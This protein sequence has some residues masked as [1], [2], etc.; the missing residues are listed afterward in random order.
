MR[1]A[2]LSNESS[3]GHAGQRVT[4]DLDG[5]LPTHHV[6]FV[7]DVGDV[8]LLGR[9]LEG[10]DMRALVLVVER[11]E[12][13]VADVATTGDRSG[14]GQLVGLLEELADTGVEVGLP[15]VQEAT[16]QLVVLASAEQVEPVR[17]EHH[18]L[19]EHA[20]LV[21]RVADDEAAATAILVEQPL[22][23][24]LARDD[25]DLEDSELAVHHEVMSIVRVHP[26]RGLAGGI[27]VEQG[28]CCGLLNHFSLISL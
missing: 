10:E 5:I 17:H 25:A 1:S 14:E 2:K 21:G 7:R 4:C 12:R 22:V 6:D 27:V 11:E 15:V 8:R 18:D 24:G 28:P 16:R 19:V 9:E 13:T 20:A 3:D 23:P 26:S